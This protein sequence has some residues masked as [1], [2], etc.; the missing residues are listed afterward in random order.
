MRDV[1]LTRA[2][3]IDAMLV[4]AEVSGLISGLRV[5]G[6]E[7]APL[8]EAE[9]DRRHPER[10][11]RGDRSTGVRDGWAVVEEMWRPTM[12]WPGPSPRRSANGAS[13]A[14]G[15]SRRLAALDLRHRRLV[16]Q[17]RARRTA[18]VSPA[19]A[20]ADLPRR[21]RSIGTRRGRHSVVRR[22]ARRSSATLGSRRRFVATVTADELE[23]PR[24]GDDDAGYP[25]PTEH[26]VVGCI[27][28]VMD[29]EWNHHQ[30][31][32]P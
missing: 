9:L 15:R 11:V 32:D 26:S 16:R 1:D 5:N 28:V 27:H 4:D 3:I 23:R 14:S 31:A 24:Q 22:R 30:Y 12:S 10:G 8:I 2:R 7:V 20:G 18:A 19:G 29:E 13:R 21:R 25:P 6:V 17:G